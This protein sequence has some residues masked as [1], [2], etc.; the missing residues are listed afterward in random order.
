MPLYCG[1]NGGG[2]VF[3]PGMRKKIDRMNK[4]EKRF[5]FTFEMF[6]FTLPGLFIGVD[7]H[8]IC[9]S[10]ID[11]FCRRVELMF[12]PDIYRYV[13][14]CVAK[15][16]DRRDP[17]EI[18]ESAI[19]LRRDKFGQMNQCMGIFRHWLLDRFGGMR[20]NVSTE[21]NIKWVYRLSL[22]PTCAG[23]DLKPRRDS[24]GSNFSKKPLDDLMAFLNKN[25]GFVGEK[26]KEYE[27]L[28]YVLDQC[29]D[30]GLF[31]G[32]DWETLDE[33]G[34]EEF[35]EDSGEEGKLCD[36]FRQFSERVSQECY[37]YWGPEIDAGLME[38][39]EEVAEPS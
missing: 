6:A 32:P 39:K 33:E 10:T 21:P 23:D 34:D 36:K 16:I 2:E 35:D 15:C 30:N 12:A 9:E 5:A 8:G 26:R 27:R 1:F 29:F 31:L 25:T 14:L 7:L 22:P 24:W 18:R 38:E 17:K 37:A 20:T 13:A 4:E 19:K 11:I 28:V 3:T